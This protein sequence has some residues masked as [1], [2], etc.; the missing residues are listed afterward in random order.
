MIP[1][2]GESA[3]VSGTAPPDLPPAPAGSGGP[4]GTGTFTIEGR[5]AP[6][7]FVLGWLATIVGGGVL[8]VS[9]QTGA[10]AAKFVLFVVGMALLSLGL[11]SAAG[12]QAIERRARGVRPYWGPSP[13]LLFLACIP[14][15]A[16]PL[17]LLGVPLQ[18][19]GVDIDGP[20]VA[21]LA[22]LVQAAVYVL[23][24]RLVVVDTGALSWSEMRIRR[25]SVASFG[26]LAYG[27][28][29]ALPI[30][31]V[32]GLISV[33]LVTAFGVT[34]DSPLPPAS[35]PAGLV[36][37]L[38]AGAILAPIGEELFFRGFATTAWV[39]G[40]GVTRGIVRGGLF[41]AFIHVLQI[42][43]TSVTEGLAVAFIAFA[44]RVPIGLMLGWL[45]IRRDT[46]WAPIG[47]HAAFNGILVLIAATVS[48]APVP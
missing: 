40:L 11:V 33:V 21:V 1:P 13:I 15:A 27:A 42:Q 43:A 22:L 14:T 12:S 48:Q 20:P 30:I 25:P 18:L 31:F 44:V 35:D 26:E 8:F 10:G 39:K 38:I 28:V 19:A 16:L 5:T 17:I 3:P 29:W 47:L 32:T 34:P 4:L 6:A 24:I 37:N 23:L 36:L 41:F 45:F 46:I 9:L 2:D 7:L